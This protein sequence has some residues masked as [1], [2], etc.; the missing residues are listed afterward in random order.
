NLVA[1]DAVTGNITLHLEN[2]PWDQALNL[3]L[4]SSGLAHR[5]VGTVLYVAPAE[6]IAAQ[7]Q[8]APEASRQAQ[9]L[10]PLQTEYVQVNYADA[11]N[12][13]TLLTG[14]PTGSAPGV[15]AAGAAAAPGGATAIGG[16]I[17][18]DRGTATVDQ[19]TNIIIIRDVAEKL[20]EVREL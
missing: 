8:Q 5:L 9:A 6:E 15:D 18:S 16:G 12:I 2:V 11:A 3:V 1:T 13:L 20:E 19:R 17:L 7:E 14:S 4:Q 10:A